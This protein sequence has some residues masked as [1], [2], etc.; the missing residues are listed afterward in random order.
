MSDSYQQN[1]RVAPRSID[2][3]ITDLEQAEVASLKKTP[4]ISYNV[5]EKNAYFNESKYCYFRFNTKIEI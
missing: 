1:I 5:I 4:C 3:E 2:K